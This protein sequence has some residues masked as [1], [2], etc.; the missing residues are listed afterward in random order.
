MF[1]KV[2]IGLDATTQLFQLY[3]AYF[4]DKTLLN[5]TGYSKN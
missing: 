2:L 5:L 4:Y 1:I 3:G